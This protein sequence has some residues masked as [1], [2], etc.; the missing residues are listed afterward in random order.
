M[1]VDAKMLRKIT[2]TRRLRSANGQRVR[3]FAAGTAHAPER[4]GTA[5]LLQALTQINL[6]A[7]QTTADGGKNGFLHSQPIQQGRPLHR[8]TGAI[9]DLLVV[10]GVVVTPSSRIR[11]LRLVCKTPALLV[12]QRPG[13]LFQQHPPVTN[14]VPTCR[15]EA[16]RPKRLL[17]ACR[18]PRSSPDMPTVRLA[19]SLPHSNQLSLFTTRQWK[20]DTD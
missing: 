16:S 2:A 6:K 8:T 15:P 17:T 13:A 11:A 1:P 10:R 4:H 18:A 19:F 7:H 5:A 12:D 3:L 14:S 20:P 9:G